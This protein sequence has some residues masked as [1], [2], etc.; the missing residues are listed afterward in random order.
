MHENWKKKKAAKIIQKLV[1]NLRLQ[2]TEK[3]KK[4]KKKCL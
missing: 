2:C 4:Q 1:A 3:K